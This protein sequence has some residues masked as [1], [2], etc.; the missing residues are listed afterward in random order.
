F[1][2]WKATSEKNAFDLKSFEVKARPVAP[3]EGL[4]PGMTVRWLAG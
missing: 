1:A 2:T 4:R 3:A